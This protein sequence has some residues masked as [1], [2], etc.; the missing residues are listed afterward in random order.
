MK[1]SLIV[2]ASA[3]ALGASMLAPAARAEEDIKLPHE[4]WSFAGTFGTIKQSSAQRGFQVYNEVCSA[5]HS[6]KYMTYRNLAGIGLSE[7]QIKAIAA[8]KTVPGDLDD[9]GK[10]TTR[11]GVPSD[12]FVSPFPNDKAARSANNG[13][14]PPDQSLLLNAREGG[15]DY[16][17]ALV[18]L[19]YVDPPP[20]VKVP[21]GSYYNTYFPG[22]NIHMPPPL[23]DGA[24]TYADGTKATVQQEA[25]DV[26][27]FLYF[28]ANPEA[29]ERKHLGVRVVGFLALLTY[30]TYGVKKKIWADQHPEEPHKE[31]PVD[32]LFAAVLREAK[33]F[34]HF[35][36]IDPND[37]KK[38]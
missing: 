8:S 15:A 27:T 36:Y 18:G 37:G 30:V 10:P 34:W 1:S 4:D 22:H 7:A 19:G 29:T 16:I 25:H 2:A 32:K 28:A 23:V 21:D 35:I 5:C 24:V 3:L 9:D 33:S 11:P 31:H 6:M 20:G 26:A 13:A 17:Y 12:H 38:G 14:L